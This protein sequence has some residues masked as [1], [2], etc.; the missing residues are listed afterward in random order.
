MRNR[1]RLT[2]AV[3]SAALVIAVAPAAMA[4]APDTTGPVLAARDASSV[5]PALP[6]A[7][8]SRSVN[9]ASFAQLEA[10]VN[11]A[12]PG[13]TILVRGGTYRGQ[14]S[15]SRSGTAAAPIAI[16]PA[17]GTGVVVLSASL[18][19]P[20]CNA[21]GPDGDRTIEFVNGASYWTL[22]GLNIQGG[23]LISSKNASSAQKWF[24]LRIKSGD[25]KSRRAVPGRGTKNA[26]AARGALQYLSSATRSPIVP[27][28]NLVMTGNTFTGKGVFGR[29]TRYGTFSGNTITQIACGTG[30]A[31]WLTTYSDGWTVSNNTI[32][33]VAES[34]ASHYMQEGIRLGNASAYNTVSGNTVSDLS[35]E[36]RAFT[37]DQDASWNTFEGNTA[38]RVDIGFNDQ[39]SGWGNVWQY[40]TAT[41]YRRAGFSLRMKDA[42]AKV[43]SLA[44]ATNQAV[45]R[46][47][48]AVGSRDLQAGSIIGTQF[49]SNSFDEVFLGKNLRVY[50]G[51]QGNRWNG[52]SAAPLSGPR[53]NFSL[54][55]C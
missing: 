46:C 34:T 11:N 32:S 35:G 36:G 22:T 21:T 55:G 14:L 29:A 50:F 43:P 3:A 1:T 54:A 47:N 53:L 41:E 18:K 20:N 23:V 8:K 17:P 48:K 33:K 7:A 13:D 6:A 26:T 15:I 27:S 45:L 44:T 16:K 2:S 38:A 4:Q 40:N 52:S 30:P 10:A 37:T 19:M 42:G 9:V 5:A 31:V 51:A 49:Q 39:M 28:D 12:V 25:Y 24:A